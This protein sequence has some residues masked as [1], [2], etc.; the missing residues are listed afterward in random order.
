MQTE[1]RWVQTQMA[2]TSGLTVSDT[3]RVRRRG[4]VEIPIP[5]RVSPA[6]Q[7]H[8]CLSIVVAGCLPVCRRSSFILLV[9]TVT[10]VTVTVTA[11]RRR[12]RRHPP[13]YVHT[14]SM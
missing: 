7:C 3:E 4:P 12:R 2:P 9:T 8:R 11:V 6:C 1:C 14:Y 13:A 10:T 5:T